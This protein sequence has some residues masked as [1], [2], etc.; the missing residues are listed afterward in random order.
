MVSIGG[1]FCKVRNWKTVPRSLN[2]FIFG[3]SLCILL[4]SCTPSRTYRPKWI[5]NPA[6]ICIERPEESGYV[7]IAAVNIFVRDF[8]TIRLLGGQAACSY[9]WAGDYFVYARSYDPYDPSNPNPQAWKSETL[10]FG[11][12]GGEK[13]ELVVCRG[14]WKSHSEWVLK[15]ANQTNGDKC[16]VEEMAD[17]LLKVK[18]ND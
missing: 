15:Y 10:R 5:E 17:E 7:N 11:V 9:V 3:I 8:Q 16:Q 4:V 18:K 14:G 13:S 12:A 2:V 6:Q 1:R